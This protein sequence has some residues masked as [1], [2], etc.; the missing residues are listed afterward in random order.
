MAVEFAF[1]E[2]YRVVLMEV[3]FVICT[4]AKGSQT[5]SLKLVKSV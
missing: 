5:V 4:R 1:T 2:W 3:L